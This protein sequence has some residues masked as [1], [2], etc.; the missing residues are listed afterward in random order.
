MS[1]VWKI[2]KIINAKTICKLHI[3]QSYSSLQ[4]INGMLSVSLPFE[5][6]TEFLLFFYLSNFSKGNTRSPSSSILFLSI[7]K[8]GKQEQNYEYSYL[9]VSKKLLWSFSLFQS[10]KIH[11]TALTKHQQFSLISW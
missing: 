3:I 2:K 4:F 9:W 10:G 6:H 7:G 5:S 1:E 8:T 11:P